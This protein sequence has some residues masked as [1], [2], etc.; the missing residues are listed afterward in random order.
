VRRASARELEALPGW[1]WSDAREGAFALGL[2]RLQRYVAREGHARVPATHEEAGYNLGA[3]VLQT[4]RSQ[5]RPFAGL[6]GEGPA[7]AARLDLE[8]STV[9]SKLLARGPSRLSF[10]R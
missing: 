8:R 4:P 3:W 1:T 6:P 5:E 7:G 9:T 2:E 10:N